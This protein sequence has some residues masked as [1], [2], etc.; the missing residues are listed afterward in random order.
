[1]T[2]L[3]YS[4]STMEDTMRNLILTLALAALPALAALGQSNMSGHDMTMGDHAT[5]ADGVHAEAT[6]NS[7]S[8]GMANVSHG[9]IPDIGWPAMTM[10]MTFLDG[11]EM[12]GVAPGEKVMMTLEKG[13]DGM[14]GIRALMPME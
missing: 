5:T 2:G 14:F 4:R 8:E 9:P 12:D 13:P 6:L 10:D 11:A 1:M 3:F 7:L